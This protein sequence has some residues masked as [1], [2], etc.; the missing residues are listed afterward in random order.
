MRT[1]EITLKIGC[2]NRCVYC[3]QDMLIKAYKGPIWMTDLD[4]ATILSNT[5]DDVRIDFSGF[6]E[7]FLHEQAGSFMAKSILQGRSTVLYT[8][9]VGFDQNQMNSIKDLTF[10]E[11]V[12]H[13]FEGVGFDKDDFM[14]KMELFRNNINSLSFRH[15]VLEPQWRWSRAGNVWDMEVKS[16]KFQCAFAGKEFDHNVVLP[17]GDVYLCCQDY[18]LKHR[19]G[20][21]LN[22]NFDNLERLKINELS[23]KEDSDV[24]CRKCELFRQI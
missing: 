20:N 17:N 1:L 11:V 15:V 7:A 4:Y 8:T 19:I 9:L 2:K 3:P 10:S 24:I 5:P 23:N 13:E 14:R 22:T 6:C 16:G 12:F 18:G 21:L